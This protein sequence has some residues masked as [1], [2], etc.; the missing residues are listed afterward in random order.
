MHEMKYKKIFLGVIAGLIIAVCFVP[1]TSADV[2][3]LTI[4][5]GCSTLPSY[6]GII[7]VNAGTYDAYVRL[8]KRG[9]KAAVQALSQRAA[10]PYGECDKVGTV[11]AT[12]DA[13]T[14]A[15]TISLAQD[16]SVIM[17]LS[18]S[19]L[20]EIPDA[21]RPSVMLVP[22]GDSAVCQPTTEC[23]VTIAGEGAYLRPTG[24]L[25]NQN[26]L[27]VMLV[28]DP[29]KDSVASVRY[30]VG[31]K[32]RYTTPTLEAFDEKYIEFANQSLK[33]VIVYES[34]QQAVIE[35][36]ASSTH[37]D[38][39]GNFLFR[40][41]QKYPR[42]SVFLSWSLIVGVGC[43]A[44][45][46]TLRAIR[47][48]RD[49]RIHHGFI[50]ERKMTAV[51]E[52]Y[53]SVGVQRVVKVVQYLGVGLVTIAVTIG[54]I[55]VVNTYVVQI[56]AVDGHSMEKTFYTGNN[57]LV[58]KIPKTVARL[59]GRE[60]LPMRGQVVIVR[61]SFGNSVLSSEDNGSLIL[62]KRV[63][64]L[65]GE[66]VVIENGNLKVYNDEHKDGFSPDEG[67]DWQAAMTPDEATENIDIQLDSGE[68]FVT[69]D[70]R[71][72]SIDSRFNGPIGT[73]EIVGVVVGKL[74]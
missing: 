66:R 60:F 28:S 6:T 53:Y 55:V 3:D 15:G 26:S 62:I 61:A 8:A 58:N 7:D 13:W 17:Q 23:F 9:E 24:T 49:Y 30:Y 36:V 1:T 70:N 21:N 33:R 43:I 64:A 46:M 29:G 4:D 68:L 54:L 71:P 45:I 19:S 12:G 22:R 52:L 42:L 50:Q 20:A 44:M 14:K 16:D 2:E 57:V 59:N 65:P 48:R 47:R 39:F 31:N 18:S 5:T 27:H 34:G 51:E 25:L 74:W 10:Q 73:D 63:I 72:A 56:I 32:L 67:A 40:A 11:T 35:S 41:T 37:Q 69:G 38:T